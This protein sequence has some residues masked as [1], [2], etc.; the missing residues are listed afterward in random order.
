MNPLNPRALAAEIIGKVQRDQRGSFLLPFA[1]L[2]SASISKKPDILDP[3]IPLPIDRTPGTI[4]G[5]LEPQPTKVVGK[6]ATKILAAHMLG[7]FLKKTLIL[8][9]VR[10]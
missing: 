4:K 8:F 10:I 1:S 6:N 7:K 3:T 9:C 2:R 5:V